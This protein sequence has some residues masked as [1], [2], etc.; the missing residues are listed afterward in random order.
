[1][2]GFFVGFLARSV[3][4][5]HSERRPA[6]FDFLSDYHIPLPLKA[7]R[8]G[9]EPRVPVKVQLLSRQLPSAARPPLRLQRPFEDRKPNIAE[10]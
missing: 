7:E 4:G 8:L 3:N 1:M 6:F 2:N 5:T 9:F 10:I